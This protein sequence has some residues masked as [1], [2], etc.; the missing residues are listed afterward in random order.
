MLEFPQPGIT[1]SRTAE[2]GTNSKRTRRGKPN[3]ISPVI[4]TCDCQVEPK[5]NVISGSPVLRMAGARMCRTS[6]CRAGLLLRRACRR[7]KAHVSFCS[8]CSFP[9]KKRNATPLLSRVMDASSV[10]GLVSS[11]HFCSLTRYR[12]VT[13]SYGHGLWPTVKTS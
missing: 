12:V 5:R 3:R 4:I 9:A 2:A 13:G 10:A 8:Y 11:V 7:E 6:A 1:K